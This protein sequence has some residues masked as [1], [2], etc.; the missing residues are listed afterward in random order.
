MIMSMWE[1]IA[2]Y[3]Q[4]KTD[5]WKSYA[6]R[7]G[8]YFSVLYRDGQ[9]ADV[10]ISDELLMKRIVLGTRMPRGATGFPASHAKYIMS[11]SEAKA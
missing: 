9:V 1:N 7:S 3:L 8:V 5:I 10:C 6:N 4:G 11:E 2:T